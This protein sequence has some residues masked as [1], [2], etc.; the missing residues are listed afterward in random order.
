MK[1]LKVTSKA[2]QQNKQ[3]QRL[4][5]SQV[6]GVSEAIAMWL[7]ITSLQK[8]PRCGKKR[9]TLLRLHMDVRVSTV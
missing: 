3:K 1:I 6:L 9:K 2:W 4:H 5:C 8:R 7:H